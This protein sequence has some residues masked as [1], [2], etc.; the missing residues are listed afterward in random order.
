MP[1]YFRVV[2]PTEED[3]DMNICHYLETMASDWF[4]GQTVTS[5]EDGSFGRIRSCSGHSNRNEREWTVD[6]Y[7]Q[8]TTI[9]I[10][11][12]DLNTG[13]MNLYGINSGVLHDFKS[14]ILGRFGKL[15][16]DMICLKHEISELA[17]DVT[18]K[19][20]SKTKKE[21][22]LKLLKIEQEIE[23]L[24]RSTQKIRRCSYLKDNDGQSPLNTIQGEL[25]KWSY[26]KVD[27]V[28]KVLI[29]NN[30]YTTSKPMPT[31]GDSV[32]ALHSGNDCWEAGEITSF[33]EDKDVDGYGPSRV[34]RIL[35]DSG[36]EVDDIQD[37]EVICYDE[38][39][40]RMRKDWKGVK[41]VCD[42]DSSD[43]WARNIGWYTVDVFGVEEPFAYISDALRVYD[44]YAVCLR[45]GGL[46]ESDLNYPEDWNGFFTLASQD[47]Y[48]SHI[49]I[50][51]NSQHLSIRLMIAQERLADPILDPIF[52]VLKRCILPRINDGSS[53]TNWISFE[54]LKL[55]LGGRWKAALANC[56]DIEALASR[57]DNVNVSST[58]TH[59]L[60]FA[61]CLQSVEAV[62][63]VGLQN[64]LGSFEQHSLSITISRKLVFINYA[65]FSL[66]QKVTYL[67]SF[68]GYLPLV[69]Q[70]LSLILQ[71]V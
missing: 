61:L 40:N 25:V 3:L 45:K 44:A 58:K 29:D 35:F 32:F 18:K 38:Y 49:N 10:N 11:E 33:S 20:A 24:K 12:D 21:I 56:M 53:I 17:A 51:I 26:P 1:L 15:K 43:S 65:A 34:Y 55:S 57:M 31:V 47:G 59:F 6:F 23:E 13:L 7:S 42:K 67:I 69:Q 50:F 37:N 70:S 36:K 39:H 60:E 48:A 14:Y 8:G 64:V 41:H 62:S 5:V 30:M 2:C 46:K 27:S 22:L 28:K 66:E 68:P 63:N 52:E 71:P 16:K 4:I 9:T 19:I 54:R